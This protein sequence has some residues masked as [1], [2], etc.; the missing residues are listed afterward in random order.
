MDTS[1]VL[2]PL[3]SLRK[4]VLTEKQAHQSAAAH[5]FELACGISQLVPG[6]ALTYEGKVAQAP[7]NAPPTAIFDITF[8]H[9]GEVWRRF[10]TTGL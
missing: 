6:H 8:R 10:S 5:A 7:A 9:M 2:F 3:Y 1:P 4:C